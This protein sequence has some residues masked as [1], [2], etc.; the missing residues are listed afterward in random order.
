VIEAA[1]GTR[2]SVEIYA[3]LPCSS[4]KLRATAAEIPIDFGV[5]EAP[6]AQEKKSGAEELGAPEKSTG[7]RRMTTG[8]ASRLEFRVSW[9]I[10]ELGRLIHDVLSEGK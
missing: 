7:W 6:P 9:V 2:G 10:R 3:K 5:S 8:H 4:F 1:A